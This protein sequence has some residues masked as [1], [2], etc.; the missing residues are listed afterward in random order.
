MFPPRVKHRVVEERDP[1]GS[2][3]IYLGPP[4]LCVTVARGHLSSSMARR[5]IEALDPHFLRGEVFRTFHDWEALESYDSNARRLLTTW[6]VANTKHVVAA[7]FL[8]SSRLVA[9]GVSAANLMTTFAGL[10]MDAHTERAPFEA[11]YAAALGLPP[12]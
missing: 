6:L 1:R 5:W 11:A 9:M 3:E 8:V 4:D 12:G 2:L 7:D 10:T